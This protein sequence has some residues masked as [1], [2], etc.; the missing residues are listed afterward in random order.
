MLVDGDSTY[1]PALLDRNG[2]EALPITLRGVRVN[3]NRPVLSGGVNTIEVQSNWTVV[4]GF[5]FTGGSNRCFYH[6]AHEVTLRDSLVRDCPAQGILGADTG[7]GSFTMEYV[8]VRACGSGT[9]QHGVYMAT[10]E[11]DYPGAV[12]RMQHCWIH[13]QNGGNAVKSRAERNEIYYNWIENS[14]YHLLELIGPDPDGGV[15]AN[16]EREDSD[17][18][19]NVL[20]RDSSFSF[21]RIGGDATGESAGR[22]R[23]VN[24]TFV[25]AVANGSAVFRCFDA[26]ESVEM[27]NNVFYSTADGGGLRLL[28]DL[29][30]NW[31]S[32]RQIAGQN[33]WIESGS[34]DLPTAA[35]WTASIVGA[36]PGFVEPRD[37]RLPAG[38]RQP[39]A[40][41][42]HRERHAAARLPLPEP[43]R[44]AGLPSAVAQRPDRRPAA[45]PARGRRD[46]HRCL[47]ARRS[48]SDDLQRRLRE[49]HHQRLVRYR[50][51]EL[52]GPSRS[53]RWCLRFRSR[54]GKRRLAE[55]RRESP[56]PETSSCARRRRRGRP[57]SQ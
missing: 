50:A 39:A 20:V 54:R 7:S 8:E 44:S 33:N 35:E 15:P 11:E 4:E 26:L 6:H 19:G 24:N 47:R 37:A 9:G 1:A 2:S 52:R 46:R 16:L 53:T 32:G 17:V 56:L 14:L 41:R 30:A 27:H 45:A 13:D 23:F 48:G 34:I 3:G 5:E 51:L 42:R 43:A 57:A 18:V 31:V 21:V 36:D 10:N 12:F 22:Y 38:G 40:R 28:R 49:R 29:E 55:G 25:S